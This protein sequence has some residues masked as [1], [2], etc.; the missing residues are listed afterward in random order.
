VGI[1]DAQQ[2]AAADDDVTP[3]LLFGQQAREGTQKRGQ[4]AGK[5][6]QL[7]GQILAKQFLN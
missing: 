3:R 1:P 6:L 5:R 2:L 7:L 4:L